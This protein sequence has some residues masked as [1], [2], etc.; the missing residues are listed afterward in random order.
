MALATRCFRP[1]PFLLLGAAPQGVALL[2]KTKTRATPPPLETRVAVARR[3]HSGATLARIK[4]GGSQRL[5]PV[6]VSEGKVQRGTVALSPATTSF[7]CGTP[8]ERAADLAQAAIAVSPSGSKPPFASSEDA[9]AS[10][11]TFRRNPA[12]RKTLKRSTK[13]AEAIFVLWDALHPCPVGVVVWRRSAAGSTSMR[14][15]GGRDRLGR[16]A[17]PSLALRRSRPVVAVCDGVF[18]PGRNGL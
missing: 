1:F 5:A 13:T 2:Q 8:S 18:P 6:G 16:R 3:K 11:G 14:S 7:G 9:V 10:L 4:T 12:T 17:S 15:A